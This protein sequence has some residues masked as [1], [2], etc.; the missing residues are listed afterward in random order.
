VQLA[1][2]LHQTYEL[3]LSDGVGPPRFEPLTCP[4]EADV[5][6]V[7]RRMLAERKL[8]SIEVRRLGTHLFTV[9]E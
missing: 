3:Y 4:P 7:V 5:F 8:S 1:Q 2:A 6:T 9:S